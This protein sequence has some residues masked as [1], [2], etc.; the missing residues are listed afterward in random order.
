MTDDTTIHEPAPTAGEAEILLF[1]LDRSRAQFAW[2][3]GG[4]DAAGLNRR[5]PPSM[6][7]LGGLLKHMAAVE[8]RYTVDFTGEPPGPPLDAPEARADPGWVWRSAA[9]DTPEEL[10]DLWRRAVARSRAAMTKA[11]AGGGLD[12]PALY[13]T[14][15]GGGSPNLRRI[16]VDLHD[17]YVRHVGHADLLREAVDGLVGEDSPQAAGA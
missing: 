14:W 2:K 9:G 12:R 17:E 6:M 11:L 13:T 1:A 7:T 4:L 15:D 3:C 8:E 5:Q 10:Y 16:V